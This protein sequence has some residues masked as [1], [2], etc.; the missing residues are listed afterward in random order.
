MSFEETERKIQRQIGR[1]QDE[2]RRNSRRAGRTVLARI[3][4]YGAKT[5]IAIT[6]AAMS[7]FANYKTAYADTDKIIREVS[8]FNTW[9]QQNINKMQEG[10][11]SWEEASKRFEAAFKGLEEEVRRD[12]EQRKYEKAMYNLNTLGNFARAVG[13]EDILREVSNLTNL[14]ELEQTKHIQGEG[15]FNVEGTLYV[16]GIT[17]S[18]DINVARAR[19][20]T[21]ATQ[22]LQTQLQRQG[23]QVTNSSTPKIVKLEYAEGQNRYKYYALIERVND[24]ETTAK[25]LETIP[26]VKL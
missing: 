14:I 23:I 15:I 5:G 12:I 18:Q 4:R 2:L 1:E 16:V 8:N 3:R 17:S 11:M 21:N 20:I 13:D 26:R 22:H 9:L 24:K 19:A 7:L 6:L 25:I 10:T